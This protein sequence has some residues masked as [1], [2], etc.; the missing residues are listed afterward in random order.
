MK[1]AHFNRRLH[2]YLG[3]SLL[4]WFFAYGLSSVPFSHPAWGQAVY[5]PLAWKLRFER[6]YELPGTTG[7]DLR[8]IGETIARESGVKGAFG[9]YRPDARRIN[10][11][12][13]TFWNATQITYDTETR[14]LKAEDRGF[15]WDHFLTGLHARGGF[16]QDSLLDDAWAVVVDVVAVGFLVWA[17]SGIYMWWGAPR[18]RRW[19]AIALGAGAGSFGILFALL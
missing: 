18:L 10:V 11:Y 17:A 14:M 3:L 5:G 7:G 1:F 12:V 15:R 9:A 16:S 13:H 2:L 4:P 6:P 19:G 8:A